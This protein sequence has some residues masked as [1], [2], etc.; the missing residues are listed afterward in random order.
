MCRRGGERR[1]FLLSCLVAR[2]DVLSFESKGL[3]VVASADVDDINSITIDTVDG[4]VS[5]HARFDG[6]LA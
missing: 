1:R 3:S 2:R 4:V 5:P 6:R